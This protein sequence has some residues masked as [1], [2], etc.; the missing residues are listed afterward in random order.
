M[1]PS[2][3]GPCGLYCGACGATDCDGCRSD[4]TDDL[5]KVCRFRGCAGD[6]HIDFCCSCDD[7]PC[8][9]L[10][11]FMNDEWPHH[12]TMK[13]NLD[14]IRKN[15]REKWLNRQKKEWGCPSCGAEIIWYQKTCRCGQPLEGWDLPP[16]YQKK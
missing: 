3:Y 2:Q 14:Y 9:P 16:S 8:P 10:Y 13:P 5:V 7:Y 11:E 6:K 4:R 15:G 1:K 12:W